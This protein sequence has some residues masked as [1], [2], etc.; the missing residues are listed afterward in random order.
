[1]SNNI[2]NAKALINTFVTGDTQLARELLAQNYIQH[3]QAYATGADAFIA[4][5]EGL[6][7]APVQTTVQT[8]RAFEDGDK[9]FLHNLYN[10]AGSG[11]QVAFDIFRFNE[12]GK[13][14]E[15]WDNLDVLA[16]ANPSGRTQIDGVTEG[17]SSDREA[18]RALVTNFVQDILHGKN[19]EKLNSYFN[20]GK[21]LQHNTG[22]A[23]DLSGL[24]AALAE[25]ADAGL[26]MVYDKTYQVL[27]QDDFALAVSEGEFAG[28]HVAF[29]DLFRVENG[30]IAE[31][32]DVIQDIADQAA[33]D[34]GK[35]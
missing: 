22:I 6:A 19:M 20:Q 29:Y 15:H 18:T 10:F 1:M 14:A 21:Y 7:Q 26:A 8:I 30:F 23:D 17:T 34:N 16:E 5:V 31:H 12:D 27:A 9:V 13:I 2:Q 35:F 11:D 4:A 25:L 3:N 32:W 33:N 28:R 24:G